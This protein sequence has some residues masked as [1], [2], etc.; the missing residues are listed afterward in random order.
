[1]L[2]VER[3]ADLIPFAGKKLGTSEWVVIDQA[4]IDAFAEATGDRSWFHVDPSAPS[5]RCR[6][7]ARSRMGF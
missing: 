7:A 1:M 4:M 2:S 5:M 6:A 3:P